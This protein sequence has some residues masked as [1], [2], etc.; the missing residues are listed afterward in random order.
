ML[1]APPVRPPP[2]GW[3]GLTLGF[4]GVTLLGAQASIV[5]ANLDRDDWRDA[6]SVTGW[7]IATLAGAA[8]V[9]GAALLIGRRTRLTVPPPSGPAMEIPKGQRFVWLCR[10]SNRWLHLLA[11]VTGILTL[12]ATAGAVAGL[13]VCKEPWGPRP[14]PSPPARCS[15]VP[16]CRPG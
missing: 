11:A 10:T 16:P 6:G 1:A 3:A 5:R 8:V 2:P 15:P 7:V 12:A 14:S 13:G 4:T 9:A